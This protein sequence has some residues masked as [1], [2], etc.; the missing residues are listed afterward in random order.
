L[1]LGLLSTILVSAFLGLL[2]LAAGPETSLR[3]YKITNENA[4][5]GLFANRNHQALFLAMGIPIAGLL[6]MRLTA[7]GRRVLGITAGASAI[8]FL[9]TSVV[10]SQSRTG[11]AIAALS[12]VLTG[13]MFLR[14][15]RLSKGVLHALL[16]TAV[17]ALAISAIAFRTWS[18]SRLGLSQDLR[19]TIFPETIQ[20]AKTFFPFG[21]GFGT[22]PEIFPRF[23]D[24]NDLQ[25]SY[26]NHTHVE[27][28]QL[29][30]EGGLASVVLVAVFLAWYLRT[31]F[32]VWA[33][34]GRHGEVI[35]DAQLCSILLALPLIASVTDYPLRTP[36]MLCTV[37]A[38]ASVFARLAED[39]PPGNRSNQKL[40][41]D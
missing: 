38:I 30:I 32:R 4:G 26:Y 39:T 23:E 7:E 31:T 1:L 29:L 21:S 9:L 14:S 17:L 22:F 33:R 40:D 41:E 34:Q 36:L 16:G 37:A 20:A 8:V 19:V 28:T 35:R 11:S 18:P 24:L 3:F 6:A 25:P 13:L 27:P 2:Q 15:R 5:V 10:A 12:L